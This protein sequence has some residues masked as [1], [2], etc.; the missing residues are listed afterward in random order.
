MVIALPSIALSQVTRDRIIES[1]D[2][3]AVSSLLQEID[4][5][6]LAAR[7]V[8]ALNMARLC[9]EE[10]ASNR[11]YHN[12]KTLLSML[13]RVADDALLAEAIRPYLEHADVMVRAVAFE[14]LSRGRGPAVDKLIREKLR[15]TFDR[16]PSPPFLHGD[17]SHARSVSQ[18][19]EAFV[20][21]LKGLL[22]SESNEAREE[23]SRYLGFLRKRYSGSAEGQAIISAIEGE[24]KRAGIAIERAESSTAGV[25][26]T[27][28]PPAPPIPNTTPVPLPP[29]PVSNSA[30][31]PA[32]VVEH[33]LPLW[34]WLVGG[35]LALVLVGAL[36]L[37]R[38]V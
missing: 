30:D 18:N 29:P 9:A 19:A 23:G 27:P 35:I 36:A 12:G 2:T 21:C 16:L 28:A 33:G 15:S 10:F 4:T 24:L 32:S 14:A 5:M 3:D 20:F 26:P 11:E 1:I 17:E 7:R 37:K 31:N 38:R 22:K 6:S 8:T 25:T 13:P 34:P